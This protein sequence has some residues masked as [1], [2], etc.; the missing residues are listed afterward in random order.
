LEYCRR[1]QGGPEKQWTPS[2]FSFCSSENVSQNKE[3]LV[4]VP[5]GAETKLR[6]WYLMFSKSPV[7][8]QFP[9]HVCKK[10]IDTTIDS[11]QTIILGG[12]SWTFLCRGVI[13]TLFQR[14]GVTP[15]NRNRWNKSVRRGSRTCYV[16]LLPRSSWIVFSSCLMKELENGSKPGLDCTFMFEIFSGQW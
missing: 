10:S 14:C 7:R 2:F 12:R 1:Q 4:G 3:G 15:S 16:C 13:F 5:C 6:V 9:D 8:Q 11:Q